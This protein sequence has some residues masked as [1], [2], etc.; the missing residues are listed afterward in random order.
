VNL[1]RQRAWRYWLTLEEFQRLHE[2]QDSILSAIRT[3]IHGIR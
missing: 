2:L 3:E 1:L